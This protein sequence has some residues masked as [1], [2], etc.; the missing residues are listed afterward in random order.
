MNSPDGGTY[1]ITITKDNKIQVFTSVLSSVGL[2]G[3]LYYAHKEG[4]H[5]WGYVGYA[6]LGSISLGTVGGI[7]QTI[8][9]K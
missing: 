2:L 9:K 3:G 1:G 8:S 4:C 6:V 7:I 5:F